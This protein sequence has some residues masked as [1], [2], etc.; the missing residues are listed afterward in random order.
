MHANRIQDCSWP[1]K[2]TDQFKTKKAMHTFKSKR[3]RL[4]E[5]K[6]GRNTVIIYFDKGFMFPDFKF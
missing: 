2:V 4:D 1:Q 3:H 6:M 5:R